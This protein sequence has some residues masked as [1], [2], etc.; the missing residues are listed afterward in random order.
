MLPVG[1]NVRD[2]FFEATINT[3][4]QETLLLFEANSIETFAERLTDIVYDG[5]TPMLRNILVQLAE[6]KRRI[7]ANHAS[8]E[9]PCPAAPGR[10]LA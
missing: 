2:V 6:G 10:A 5:A 1:Q 9:M 7:A 8:E 3:V 4:N